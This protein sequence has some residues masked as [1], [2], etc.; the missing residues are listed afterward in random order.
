[1]YDL[2]QHPSNKSRLAKDKEIV[3]FFSDSLNCL[4]SFFL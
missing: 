1:M 2:K 4:L 3:G